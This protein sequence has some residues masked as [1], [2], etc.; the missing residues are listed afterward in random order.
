MKK[1]EGI[2]P[3]KVYKQGN[4]QI[5][6][7]VNKNADGS[8][9]TKWQFKDFFYSNNSYKHTF[10]ISLKPDQMKM[11]DLIMIEIRKD[12]LKV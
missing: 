4:L 9:Y 11:L 10:K 3:V 1:G 8:V 6:K 12:S 7:F 5:A 2:A